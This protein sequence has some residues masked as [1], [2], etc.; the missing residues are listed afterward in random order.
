M[1]K[2]QHLTQKQRYTIFVMGKQGYKVTEIAQTIGVNRTT[3]YREIKRNTKGQKYYPVQAHRM[4]MKRRWRKPW[5]I[6]SNPEIEETIK[7]SIQKQWSPEQMCKYYKK[8]NRFSLSHECVYQY[9]K[10]DKDEGGT[11]Y[12][13]LRHK[14]R[15]RKRRFGHNNRQG[16]ILGKVSIHERSKIVEERTRFGD[17]E[18]DTILSKSRQCGILTV[19]DRATR[20]FWMKK[21][22]RIGAKE[23][24]KALRSIIRS[25]K[26]PI[27]TITS[28]NGK[29][30][31]LHMRMAYEFGIKYYFADPYKACQRGTNENI[32]GLIRQYLPKGT[33]F[34]TISD[35]TIIN[36][37][38]LINNRPRKTLGFC[39][40]SFI[41][42]LL[43]NTYKPHYQPVALGI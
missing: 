43:S 26:L 36:I 20:M 29:E 27:H 6:K 34:E 35:K 41:I 24:S 1:S 42:E 21:V 39:S 7:Q 14:G 9:L 11:L 33:H 5:K 15:Y 16:E 23:V 22:N 28:D 37:Q 18:I 25:I 30:F 38:N 3:V 13:N 8:Q 31:A 17:L 2:Y 10:R 12:K 19:V 4:A 40:P 32:N